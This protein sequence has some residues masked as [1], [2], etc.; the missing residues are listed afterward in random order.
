MPAIDAKTHN[1]HV[2]VIYA[3]LIAKGKPK[4]SAIGATMRKLVHLCFGCCPRAN[5]IRPNG[6]TF[7]PSRHFELIDKNLDHSPIIC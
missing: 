7:E 3:R 6:N 1:P 5:R 2:K 4:M